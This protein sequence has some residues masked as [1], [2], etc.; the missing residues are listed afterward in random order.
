MAAIAL[1]SATLFAAVT[2][3][4]LPVGLL[5]QLSAAFDVDEAGIGYWVSAYAIVVAV[6]AIPL[7]ALLVRFRRRTALLGLLL[8]YALSNVVI[9]VAPGYGWALAARLIGGL[10]HAGIFTVVV[11]TA[12]AVV[13]RERAGRA[14]AVVNG[15][16]T[17][18]MTAGVPLGTAVGT[19][20]GWRWGFAGTAAVLFALAAAAW[21]VVPA[22]VVA[23]GSAPPVLPA[24]RRPALLRV[25]VATTAI[26]LGHYAA[27]TYVTPLLLGSGVPGDRVSLVLF[28]YG[29]AGFVGLLLVGTVIDKHPVAALRAAVAVVLTCLLVA[30]LAGGELATV[31]AVVAWGAGF[32]ALPTLLQT[33]ALRATGGSDAAPAVVNAT[34]NVGIAGGAGLGGALL[35][36]GAVPQAVVAGA[37]VVLGLLGAG[38]ARTARTE[39][40][41]AAVVPTAPSKGNQL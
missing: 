20:V 14:L 41:H 30:V 26:T 27:Y 18:A 37:L 24:L 31:L 39:Q 5:P 13:P 29:A 40:A 15:G 11:A 17:M 36:A 25:A 23:H 28:G 3:E 1:L 16:V 4:M 10:A 21:F 9:V 38:G 8:T 22:S 2:T 33:A 12:V 6:G 34:F 32:G 35:A 19:A 7:T